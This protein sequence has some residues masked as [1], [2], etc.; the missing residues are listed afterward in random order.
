MHNIQGF[1]YSAA[2]RGRKT[3]LFPGAVVQDLI[4]ADLT[5]LKLVVLAA[6]LRGFYPALS[7]SFKRQSGRSP[8]W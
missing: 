7:E 3:H 4:A 1:G 5:L 2:Q 6:V 8:P